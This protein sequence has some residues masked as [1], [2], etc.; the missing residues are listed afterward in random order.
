MRVSRINLTFI[1]QDL[2]PFLRLCRFDPD[3]ALKQFQEACKFREEKH[4][5]R[6]YDLVDIAD[7]EEAR[8]IVRIS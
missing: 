7:F 2:V 3:D 4:I 8:R 5:L 6:L 1:C